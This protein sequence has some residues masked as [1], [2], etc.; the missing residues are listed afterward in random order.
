ME[1]DLDTFE[2]EI[3][4]DE[5]GYVHTTT[6]VLGQG[7]QGVVYRIQD[8]DL[9]LKLSLKNGQRLINPN[10]VKKTK[11]EFNKLKYL[12]LEGIKLSTPISILNNETGYIMTLMSDM[13]PFSKFIYDE[14]NPQ[15]IN[16]L[17]I[18]DYI[19]KDIGQLE[20]Q[21][22]MAFYIKTHGVKR[23]LKS[24]YRC[25][26]VLNKL[27]SRGLFF[28]DIN[29]NNEFISD[30]LDYEEVW[31]IDADNLNFDNK[32]Q[33]VSI[34]FPKYGSPEVVNKET[35]NSIASDCYSF[36]ILSHII[37][38]QH[39]PFEGQALQN[40]DSWD[41]NNSDE[42][43]DGLS[44]LETGELPWIFSRHDNSNSAEILLGFLIQEPEIFGLFAQTFES[45]KLNV[46]ERPT[47]NLWAIG[48]ARLHDR[49]L[50]CSKCHFTFADLGDERCDCCGSEKP[51]YLEIT[52][53]NSRNKQIW[54]F[55]E[56]LGKK[57][58]KVPVRII[59]S[60]DSEQG[61]LDLCEIEILNNQF[62]IY[63]TNDEWLMNISDSHGKIYS[64]YH[65]FSD[66]IPLNNMVEIY[67]TSA[68]NPNDKYTLKLSIHRQSHGK[69]NEVN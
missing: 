37:L 65:R 36:A 50:S 25:A 54:Q 11:R 29:P 45:G 21:K 38:A 7:G 40:E 41:D 52:T 66:D 67:I 47:M 34:Y 46:F 14:Q 26:I 69:A 23:R 31:L 43:G 61:C 49:L 35:V 4:E 51:H 57:R 2:S 48:L 44:K 5:F 16:E 42:W 55:V 59:S 30:N 33:D 12:P 18:D 20:F 8:A 56:S 13:T 39:H 10:D 58:I 9:A 32:K 63:K 22:L 27:H 62:F 60:V 1:P 24:L 17:T 15:E 19:T 3:F 28:A 6:G 68:K 64:I 53:Y